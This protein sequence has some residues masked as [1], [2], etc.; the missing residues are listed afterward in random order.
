MM[1]LFDKNTRKFL[2][3]ASQVFDNGTWREAT[4]AEL[5]PNADPSQIGSVYVEDALAIGTN[6][7][8]WQ[9]KFNERGDA[10]GI[11]PKAKPPQ[12]HLTTTALD[13]DGDGYPELK[14][15]GVS[16]ALITAEIKRATGELV[17]DNVLLNFRTTGGS[18]SS[19][20]V[21]TQ[22]G[23]ATVELTASLETV[24]VTVTASAE[25]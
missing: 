4:I 11:E 18:L 2:G 7:D 10:I 21:T 9:L 17:L 12:I 15:D 23:N 14:A 8:A 22:S 16:R 13:T 6:P 24:L 3:T 25:G 5:Y 1:I 20:R 19:R